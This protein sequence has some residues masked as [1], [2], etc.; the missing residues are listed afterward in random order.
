M[1]IPDFQTLMLPVLQLAADGAQH[2]I[3]DMRER[4][5]VDL[6]L[7]ADE[8]AEKLKSGNPLFGNRVAWAVVYLKKAELLKSTATG[9]YQITDRGTTLLSKRPQ[10]ITIKTLLD[11]GFENEPIPP[12]KTVL[13][14]DEQIDASFNS[15]G[16]ALADELLEA[17][18]NGKPSALERIVVDLLLA[19]GYGDPL[20]G[21]GQVIGGPGDGGIDGVIRQDKLGLDRV[22]VQV[23][24]YQDD[25][26]VGSP[27]VMRFCGSLT[28]QKAAKGVMITT[29]YFTKDA[30]EFVRQIPQ[31]IVLIDGERLAGLMIEHGIGVQPKKTYTVKRLDQDYFDNL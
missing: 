29:S 17:V 22:Y 27:D 14:P 16:N 15:L 31:T 6:N 4:L 20:D 18:Q 28:A 5:A 1:P 11:S 25:N 13:T 3:A 23:K 12:N 26:A 24:R 8:L 7:T 19:M 2:R 21:A 9:V 30:L 10:K